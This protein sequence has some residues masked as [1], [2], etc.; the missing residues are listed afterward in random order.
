MKTI[1]DKQAET[2]AT[3]MASII[4]FALIMLIALVSVSFMILK[5]VYR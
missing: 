4:M 3:L 1:P 2:W 5:D